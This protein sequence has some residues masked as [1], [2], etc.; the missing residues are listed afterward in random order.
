MLQTGARIEQLDPADERE[1]IDE[2]QIAESMCT[3]MQAVLLN[4]HRPGASMLEI[5]PML[6]HLSMDGTFRA[7]PLRKQAACPGYS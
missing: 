2:M 5:G 1:M 6:G 7:K 4:H 3:C